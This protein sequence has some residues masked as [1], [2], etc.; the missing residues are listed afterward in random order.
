MTQLPLVADDLPARRLVSA[1]RAAV[2]HYDA[3]YQGLDFEAVQ[4]TFLANQ[5]VS[6]NCP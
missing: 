2:V 1:R 5:V 4:G 6:S 3:S